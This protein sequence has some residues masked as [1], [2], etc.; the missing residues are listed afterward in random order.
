MKFINTRRFF[1]LWLVFTLIFSILISYAKV[2]GNDISNSVLRLH[3]LA[4]SNSKADQALKLAVRDRII[5][6]TKHIFNLADSP[7]SA[8]KL[9][10]INL[11]LIQKIAQDEIE[12]H[13]FSSPV[14]ASVTESAFPTKTYDGI[15][16][17]KGKYQALKIEIGEASG[18][19]WWCV[20]YPPLCYTDGILSPSD[21]AKQKLKSTLNQ[22]EYRLVT[23]SPKG[24]VPVEI[25]FKIV[26]LFQNIF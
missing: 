9:A 14:K 15:T 12:K 6:D 18:E 7:D 13:G 3:I 16:L 20:M 2:A 23:K 21:E 22:D 11:P 17:P 10:E 1:S 26:E 4:N 19:N 24:N 8:T 25:R 5:K